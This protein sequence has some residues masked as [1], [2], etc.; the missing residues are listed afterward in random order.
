M[1]TRSFYRWQPSA[2]LKISGE[3]AATFL[4]GQFTNDL[5]KTEG[6][7]PGVYGLWLNQKGKVLADSFVLGVEGGAFWVGSYFSPAAVIRERLE[8]YV[9]A[10]DVVIEDETP[11]W[12]GVTVYGEAALPDGVVRV[13]ARRGVEPAVEWMFPAADAPRVLAALA[14]GS[15][16]NAADMERRRISGGVPAVPADIGPTEL[17]NEGGLDATAISYTKGCYLGQE[18]MA[19]LKSLGQVRRRLV[20]VTG[21]GPVPARGTLLYQGAQKV[22]EIRTTAVNGQGYLGLALVTLLNLQRDA[23][24]SLAPDAPA[25]LQLSEPAE[26]SP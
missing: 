2:W 18:V 15:E 8:A 22:G 1:K 13:G 7:H 11:H 24:L 20:R 17:P 9:I 4:Q 3:D 21:T 25:T 10:D 5:R 19:R 12:A 14:G 6:I 16:L 26:L 23:G